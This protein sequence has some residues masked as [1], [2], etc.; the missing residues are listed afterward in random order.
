M[1]SEDQQALLLEAVSA[2][3]DSIANEFETRFSSWKVTWTAE[4]SLHLSDPTFVTHSSEFAALVAMGHEVLP[5][6]VNK[7]TDPEN[8]LALQ[9]FEALEIDAGARIDIDPSD[10]TIFEGEQG[11]ARRTVDRWIANL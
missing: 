9:L 7:L 11:R 10:E 2:V 3:N 5:L 6:V 4:H 8:F 1:D